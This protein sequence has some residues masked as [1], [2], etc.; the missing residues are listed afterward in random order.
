[1]PN[2]YRELSL[3]E[4]LEEARSGNLD[5]D[6][7][8]ERFLEE[9]EKI[10]EKFKVFITLRG[11]DEIK[12]DAEKIKKKSKKGSL[13]FLP[14]TVKDNICTKDLRT[15]CGSKMLEDYVPFF[16]ATVVNN[17]KGEDA[18]LIGKTA[19]DEFGFGTFSTNCAFGPPLNPNDPKRVTGGSS[20]G[21]AAFTKAMEMPHISIGQS[22]GG[23]ISCPSCFCGVFGLTPTYGVVSRYGL[24]D[25]GNSLDKIG[26]ITKHA[27]D[28]EIGFRVLIKGDG[29]D[30]TH[31]GYEKERMKDYDFEKMRFAVV[32]EY[33]DAV[34]NEDVKKEVFKA[35]D[36]IASFVDVEEVSIP[37]SKY[38]LAAY[39]IVATAE[40]STNLAKFCGMRYGYEENPEGLHFDDYFSMI[41]S[42]AFGDEVKRRI[43]LGSFARMA[44]Y[45]DAYYLR[46]LKVRRLII[47]EF[48]EA[49]KKYD[50]LLAPTMPT[51]APRFEEVDKMKPSDIYAMDVLTVC[52]NFAGIPHLNAPCGKVENMPVGLHLLGDH[53]DDWKLIKAAEFLEREVL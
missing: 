17:F 29:K 51:I 13:F 30:S 48:K 26:L 28:L 36:K 16:D 18:L 41:R 19:M 38:G 34:S 8:L 20:G 32:K 22:T 27:E 43:L 49:F 5:L 1:M 3:A 45:R 4:F 31:V 12:S 40:A 23:S 15:T 47:N 25:Y 24:I 35:V 44:G 39:Y 52:P 42:K 21:A 10:N 6:D 9:T 46:A 14:F 11:K 37:S 53:F 7:Y 33:F 50:V 2:E